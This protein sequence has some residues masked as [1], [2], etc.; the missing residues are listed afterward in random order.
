MI[1]VDSSNI[2][3]RCAF[4]VSSGFTD[5]FEGYSFL[6]E[7]REVVVGEMSDTEVELIR[8]ENSFFVSRDQFDLH[9]MKNNMGQI[10]SAYIS[11]LFKIRNNFSASMSNPMVLDIDGGNTWRKK[12]FE[13]NV[14]KMLMK[15]DAPKSYKG[16]RNRESNSK[17]DW[18][19][20]FEY[21]D[22]TLNAIKN[23]TDFIVMT[24]NSAE[25]DDVIA[26]IASQYVLNN[27]NE[28]VFII[29][30]DED[31][32]QLMVNDRIHL[33]S[34]TRDDYITCD[35]P[36]TFLTVHIMTGDGADNIP[37]ID[38]RMGEK[39]ALK[40]IEAGLENYL[41]TNAEIR[42]RFEIN[43]KL[44]DFNEIP[45]EIRQNILDE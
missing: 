31:F 7:G 26:V 22:E 32:V 14:D 25:A 33:W 19:I 27:E 45:L 43:K 36:K 9:N 37:S 17:I 13:E 28:H 4:A 20:L 18:K 42:E 3:F 5:P 29:S 12:I 8:G 24:V 34:P 39:T 16:G 44:I 38:K 21:Y 23:Y 2:F 1:L 11:S 6:Y 15:E 30:S 40:K 10:I 35:D 41:L